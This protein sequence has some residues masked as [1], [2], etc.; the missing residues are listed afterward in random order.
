MKDAVLHHVFNVQGEGEGEGGGKNRAGASSSVHAAFNTRI[1]ASYLFISNRQVF[2]RQRSSSSSDEIMMHEKSWEVL[3][4]IST[5]RDAACCPITSGRIHSSSDACQSMEQVSDC[6]LRRMIPRYKIIQRC[7][8]N[9]QTISISEKS[10]SIKRN[11]IKQN[12]LTHLV[13]VIY[14]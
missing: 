1:G 5:D 3:E 11:M 7:M 2:E 13:S 6:E 10:N 9:D 12:T 4:N 14:F 8:T